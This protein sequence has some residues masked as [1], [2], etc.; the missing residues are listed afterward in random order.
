[1]TGSFLK[2]FRLTISPGGPCLFMKLNRG[3]ELMTI[4]P[5][6]NELLSSGKIKNAFEWMNSGLCK[7]FEMEYLGKE[8]TA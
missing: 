3:E 8:V 2:H 5:Y 7:I 6:V 4:S 1:M